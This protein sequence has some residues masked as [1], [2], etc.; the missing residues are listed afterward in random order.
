MLYLLVEH[1]FQREFREMPIERILTFHNLRNLRGNIEATKIILQREYYPRPFFPLCFSKPS[2]CLSNQTS[3]RIFF[4]KSTQSSWAQLRFENVEHIDTSSLC[5]ENTARKHTFIVFQWWM[6]G[7][8]QKKKKK[9]KNEKASW[10]EAHMVLNIFHAPH[11][12]RR[13][14]TRESEKPVRGSP[15]RDFKRRNE[16]QALPATSSNYQSSSR[17]I[18]L[19]KL[20]FRFQEHILNR[21]LSPANEQETN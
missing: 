14:K 13:I 1:K 8:Q 7:Q 6:D 12:L 4:R 2:P 3:S 9:K 18:L 5:A 19:E 15:R 17:W 21:R 16:G 20:M 11:P 10:K